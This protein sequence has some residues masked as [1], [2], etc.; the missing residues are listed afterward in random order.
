MHVDNEISQSE[1]VTHCM[2]P[3]FWHSGKGIIMD[4]IKRLV[5][6]RD[7]GVRREGWMDGA[8]GIF[9]TVQLFCMILAWWLYVIIHL[10]KGIEFT[11]QN[12]P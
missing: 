7:S 5:V 6:A 1:K 10:P 9:S 11:A 4:T 12:E 3:S 2:I 8:Q